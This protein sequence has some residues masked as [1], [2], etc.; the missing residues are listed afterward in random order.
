MSE[1][2]FRISKNQ[3]RAK[4]L[5]VM[6]KERLEDIKRET[7]TYKIIEEYYE[8][9][10]EVNTSLMYLDG[11][12]TLSHKLLIEYLFKNYGKF[13]N[14]EEFGLMDELRVLRNNILYYGQKVEPIFLKNKEQKIKII[15]KK[16]ITLCGNKLKN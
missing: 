2:I 5:L 7:K 6:A 10:K 3:V 12:K 11:F 8:I 13:F 1:D 16:L 4:S 15:I 9:I 14:G